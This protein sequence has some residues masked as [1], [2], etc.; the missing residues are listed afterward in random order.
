MFEIEE[1]KQHIAELEKQVEQKKAEMGEEEF[2][3]AILSGFE[4]ATSYKQSSCPCDR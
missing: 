2:N 1:L 3:K 4:N